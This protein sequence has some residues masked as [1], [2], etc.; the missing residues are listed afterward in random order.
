M[1]AINPEAISNRIRFTN[2][3]RAAMR[4]FIAERGA[5]DSRLRLRR[6]LVDAGVEEFSPDEERRSIVGSEDDF[7]T[8]AAEQ[9]PDASIGVP[10]RGVVALVQRE[11]VNIAVLGQPPKRHSAAA[12]ATTGARRRAAVSTVRTRQGLRYIRYRLMDLFVAHFQIFL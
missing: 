4:S 3:V 12:A 6:A 1:P 8:G 9:F 2:E 7:V 10:M 11:A 5:V